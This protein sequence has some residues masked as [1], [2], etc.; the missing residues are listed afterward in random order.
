MSDFEKIMLYV[1]FFYVLLQLWGRLKKKAAPVVQ[2]TSA[3]TD[4]VAQ[5]IAQWEAAHG[6]SI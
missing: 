1:A 5:F 2:T 3:E 4:P 6:G